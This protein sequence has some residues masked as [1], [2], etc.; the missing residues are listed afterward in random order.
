MQM[1][2]AIQRDYDRRKRRRKMKRS[3]DTER[4]SE[5]QAHV[6]RR[7]D[8]AAGDRYIIG[9]TERILV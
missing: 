1:D 5:E 2:M 6:R 3:T 9:R 7:E 4:T 8:R